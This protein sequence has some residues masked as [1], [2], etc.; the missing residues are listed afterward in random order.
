MEHNEHKDSITTD[1]S[2]KQPELN[3]LSGGDNSEIIITQT[4]ETIEVTEVP[5]RRPYNKTG[6]RYQK[7]SNKKWT[8]SGPAIALDKNKNEVHLT[9]KT[10]LSALNFSR[11]IIGMKGT[12]IE[13]A[14]YKIAELNSLQEKLMPEFKE[15]EIFYLDSLKQFT[16]VKKQMDSLSEQ[17]VNENNIIEAFAKYKDVSS[18]EKLFKK[19]NTEPEEGKILGMSKSGR[20]VREPKYSGLKWLDEAVLI[21]KKEN[22]FMSTDEIWM[23]FS[24]NKRIVEA[25]NETKTGFNNMKYAVRD[26]IVNHII[27]PDKSGKGKTLS[28]YQEKIGLPDWIKN[29]SLINPEHVK[30]FM[31]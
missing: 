15:K 20:V 22:K 16:D 2:I 31:G 26:S 24:K 30:A 1:E 8:K 14:R 18:G 23:E 28:M 17:I 6:K 10:E 25:A 4:K 11:H 19:V 9:G 21:L 12:I 29:N 5:K 13:N 7:E 27:K 3:D